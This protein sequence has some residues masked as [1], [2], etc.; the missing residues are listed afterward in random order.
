M[1]NEREAVSQTTQTPEMTGKDKALLWLAEMLMPAML[2][3]SSEFKAHQVILA[4]LHDIVTMIALVKGFE[5]FS[6]LSLPLGLGFVVITQFA[7]L[8]VVEV[9]ELARLSKELNNT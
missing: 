4:A 6:E 5:A 7:R 8:T 3:V 1:M 9:I 2:S